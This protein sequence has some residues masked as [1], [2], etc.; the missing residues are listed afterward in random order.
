MVFRAGKGSRSAARLGRFSNG[1]RAGTPRITT[2]R[3]SLGQRGAHYYSGRPNGL[4]VPTS[5]RSPAPR[6]G[7]VATPAVRPLADS[8]AAEVLDSLNRAYGHQPLLTG[9]L[10]LTLVA[11]L[12]AGISFGSSAG[13]AFL[14]GAMGVVVVWSAYRGESSDHSVV[15][16][17]ELEA[18]AAR[19][20]RRLTHAFER[21]GREAVWHVQA[22]RADRDRAGATGTP[23]IVRRRAHP[24]LALPPRVKSNI[25][26]PAL[27][28]GRQTLY[29]FPDRVLVYEAQLVWAVPYHDLRVETVQMRVR[30]DDPAMRDAR[31]GHA[32]HVASGGR[33]A[34]SSSGDPRSGVVVNGVLKLRSQTGLSEVFRC[35]SPTATAEIA[36]ALA[37]IHP[38]PRGAGLGTVSSPA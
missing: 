3:I 22:K 8:S 19:T 18:D 13:A 32:S 24:R 28:A 27:P 4:S 2:A 1:R 6:P 31:R 5:R 36:A 14:F 20:Y 10:G 35:S 37:A 7:S 29:F 38:A 26:V 34:G 21:L 30:A 23:R 12:I 33:R 15:V 25:K 16:H 9:L 17:Y 11:G